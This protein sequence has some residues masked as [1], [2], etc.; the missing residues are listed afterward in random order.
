MPPVTIYKNNQL[1]ISIN[2]EDHEESLKAKQPPRDKPFVKT[3]RR[4]ERLASR[5]KLREENNEDQEAESLVTTNNESG[6]NINSFRT[7]TTKPRS[8]SRSQMLQGRVYMF[9]EHPTGWV[10]FAYHMGVFL[11]VLTCLVFSVLSTITDYSVQAHRAL[12]WMVEDSDE[13]SPRS[14]LII[15][16]GNV[17]RSLLRCG[18]RAAGLERGLCLQIPGALGPGQV[19]AETHLCDRSDVTKSLVTHAHITLFARLC[20]GHGLHLC[21][22]RRQ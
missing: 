4:L 8:L 10:C 5:G 12:F 17:P 20:G 2:V 11:S 21:P 18:V 22:D 7:K 3:I 15:N 9:L 14:N 6:V 16:T 1:G 19:Y 13:H